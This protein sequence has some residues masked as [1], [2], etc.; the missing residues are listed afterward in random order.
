VLLLGE[1]V[2]EP[3]E[4]VP[5]FGTEEKPECDMLYNVTTMCTIWNTLA[6]RDVRLLKHQLELVETLPNNCMFQNYLRCHDDIGWGLDY[7]Y[8]GWFGLSENTHKKYL[9]DWFTGKWEG[10]PSRGELYNDSEMLQ[11]ARLC[12]TTAS[13]CGVESALFE[14]NEEALSRGIAA[15]LMLHALM[16]TL[17]GI[18]VLYSGDELGMLNDYGY[19]EDPSKWSDSRNLHRGKFP[20]V[21]AEE[22]HDETTATGRIFQG[23]EKLITIRSNDDIFHS[24]ASVHTVKTDDDRVLGLGREY[25][26]KRMLG[27]F[28]F[29]EAPCTVSV[30]TAPWRDMVEPEREFIPGEGRTTELL[31]E[32]YG[33]RWFVT[34]NKR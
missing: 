7:K 13:L 11:D 15:D 19:H 25:N 14:N 3:K 26:G 24:D 12:G 16:L 32:P 10:S 30:P 2:M 8:L 27:L 6:T 29:S 9:N 23:I 5:Y 28:N 22:R 31:L 4:V 34:E 17:K 21:S 18:P 33:F 1:V 20:W